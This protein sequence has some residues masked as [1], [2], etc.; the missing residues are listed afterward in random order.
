M[1]KVIEERRLVI[2]NIIYGKG[3]IHSIINIDT[4][5]IAFCTYNE[6]EFYNQKYKKK[7]NKINKPKEI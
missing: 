4:N 2:T 3:D 1:I 6:I 5:F 7:E